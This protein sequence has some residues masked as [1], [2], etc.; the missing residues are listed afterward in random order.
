MAEAF[1]IPKTQFAKLGMD[2]IAYQV[3]GDG[4]VDLL[5]VPGIGD[6]LDAR[7]DYGPLASLLSRLASFSRLI[8][9][10]RRGMGASDPVPL[11]ALPSWEEFVDDAL[12]VLDAAGSQ[13][14]VLLG[15]TDAAATALLFAATRPE[16]T[17]SVILFSPTVNVPS[18]ADGSLVLPRPLEEFQ[19]LLASLEEH[20]GTEEG[21]ALGV[22]EQADDPV[23]V[24]FHAKNMR[25]SCSPRQAGAYL[26]QNSAVDIRDVLPSIKVPTLLIHRQEAPAY[27]PIES[28]RSL[29]DQIPGARLVL[30][31]GSGLNIYVK[32]YAQ[33]LDH[34]EAFATGTT[35]E[36]S[37]HRALATILFTDI[38]GSTEQASRLGDRRWS[39][40]L[41]SHDALANSI[42]DQHGGRLVKLT[43]DGVLATFDGPGRAIRCATAFR[44]ALAPLGITIRAGLHSG[45]VE[46]RGQDIGGIAVHLAARVLE[47]AGPNELVT[48]SAVPLLVAGSRIDFEDRGEH[49]LKGID[50]RWRLYTVET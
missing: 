22:P 25:I 27:I 45:E 44:D 17:R 28:V 26:L 38:V 46:L 15:C 5:W 18:L 33:T 13:Q 21:A 4:P 35:P 1:E 20:W 42:I 30:V 8:M 23:L 43:G 19:A 49:E 34:I 16:R 37:T 9:M 36:A 47:Q 41:E 3:V 6:A 14:A 40:L 2:R 12:T 48:S 24:R 39:G 11:D 32:P 50:G 29:A 31:P 7:W 10:D